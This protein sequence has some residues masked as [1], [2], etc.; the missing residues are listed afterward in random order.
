MQKIIKIKMVTNHLRYKKG[1]VLDL[2]ESL[3]INFLSNGK[4]LKIHRKKESILGEKLSDKE[5][6]KSKKS[7]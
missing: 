7:N 6:K 4:A 3:A 1:Q 2:E 5:N